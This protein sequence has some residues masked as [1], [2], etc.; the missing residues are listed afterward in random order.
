MVIFWK[1]AGRT[2]VRN[3]CHKDV[4]KSRLVVSLGIMLSS[5]AR[6]T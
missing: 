3:W 5:A 2:C 4:L 1:I 6:N